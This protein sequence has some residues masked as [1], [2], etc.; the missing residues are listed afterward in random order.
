MKLKRDFPGMFDV[1]KGILM[2]LV[3][4]GHQKGFFYS[5]LQVHNLFTA[6][7]LIGGYDVVIMGLFFIM[8]G[9]TSHPE[10]NLKGY[11]KKSSRA[12]LIP[13]F[14]T[15]IVILMIRI[16]WDICVGTFDFEIIRSIIFGFL[17]GNGIS[18]GLLFGQ[19]PAESIGA[20]WFLLALFWSGLLHQLLLRIPNAVARA[21]LIWGGTIAAVALP[22]AWHFQFP[23]ALV[24]GC[25]AVGFRE[26]GRLLRIQKRFYQKINWPFAVMAAVL[27]G[28]LHFISTAKFWSN[29]WQFWMLDYLSAAAMGVVLLHFYINSGLAVARFTDGLAYIGR[30]SLFFFCLHNIEMLIFPWR[31]VYAFASSAFHAPWGIAFLIILVGRIVFSVAG[32]HFILWADGQ[33]KKLRRV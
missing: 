15:M 21:L 26:I 18:G 12:L 14:L 3:I 13:Y 31:R 16:V 7:P 17:Y 2:L 4:L 6:S 28:A 25:T 19:F 33:L 32:C 20:A 24:P 10:K 23:W 27:S 5:T 30:Y 11:L 29:I 8:A 1:A 9:Y 22:D